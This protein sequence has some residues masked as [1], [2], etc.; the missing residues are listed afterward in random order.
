MA[1]KTL[2]EAISEQRQW[3]ADHGSTIYGYVQRYGSVDDPEHYGDGGE[4]IFHADNDALNRLLDAKRRGGKVI[5]R[6]AL[7]LT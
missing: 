2:D 7:G 5:T 3:I 4:A 6:R 1:R